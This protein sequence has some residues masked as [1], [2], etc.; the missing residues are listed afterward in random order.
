M[1]L[2]VLSVRWYMSSVL[3]LLQEQGPIIL[4]FQLLCLVLRLDC[5]L[6]LV[7]KLLAITGE[8]YQ[9]LVYGILVLILSS[10]LLF[11]QIPQVETYPPFIINTSL[12]KDH[13]TTTIHPP[14][15]VQ[16]ME[17]PPYLPSH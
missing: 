12:F 11:H 5:T 8:D 17:A 13:T 1:D 3:L 9:V 10:T 16:L 4:K 7:E 14:T 6:Y 15:T 2:A